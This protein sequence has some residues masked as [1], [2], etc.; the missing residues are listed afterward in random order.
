MKAIGP[1]RK[2]PPTIEAGVNNFSF[3]RSRLGFLPR[4]I[5]Q[6]RLI[7]IDAFSFP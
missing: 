2:L 7:L 5:H 3:G 1:V 6:L 4:R